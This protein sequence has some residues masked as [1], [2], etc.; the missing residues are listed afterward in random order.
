MST[1]LKEN[2][3]FAGLIVLAFV[4]MIGAGLVR[5]SITGAFKGTWVHRVCS[6]VG[7]R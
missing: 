6:L 7:G 2:I 5:E 1:K 3:K 4:V